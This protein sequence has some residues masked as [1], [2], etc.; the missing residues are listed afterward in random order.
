MFRNFSSVLL[1]EIAPFFPDY[2]LF[3][4]PPSFEMPYEFK[5]AGYLTIS[6]H[7]DPK[8]YI[9]TR[10]I[11]ENSGKHLPGSVVEN[12]LLP[13]WNES[14]VGKRLTQLSLEEYQ[15]EMLL[16]VIYQVMAKAKLPEDRKEYENWC[17]KYVEVVNSWIF[18]GSAPALSLW[19]T[20]METILDLY[21]DVAI[22][23]ELEATQAPE[24]WKFLRFVKKY[25]L[26]NARDM[27]VRWNWSDFSHI[28]IWV[29]NVTGTEKKTNQLLERVEKYR[30][31][32][33]KIHL[34]PSLE[35]KDSWLILGV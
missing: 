7:Q 28:P 33:K 6:L 14:R 17:R 22:F 5:K 25:S 32:A 24:E 13:T 18:S 30:K 27:Q 15:K 31:E 21:F 35:G 9:F 1:E 2:V 11:V 8:S 19:W 34:F 29:I 16:W 20:E 23:F 26:V 10:G 3:V 12:V 4:N